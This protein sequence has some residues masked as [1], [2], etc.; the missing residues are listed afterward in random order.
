MRDNRATGFTGYWFANGLEIAAIGGLPTVAPQILDGLRFDENGMDDASQQRMQQVTQV[1]STLTSELVDE[2][3]ALAIANWTSASLTAEQLS[4]L[5]SSTI[6]IGNLDDE[7]ALGLTGSSRIVLDDDALG[8]GW[9]VGS[10]SETVPDG[11]MDLL[12]VL[13]HEM[14]HVLGF[15]DLDGQST[16]D[17]LMAGTLQP[18]QRRSVSSA[19]LLSGGAGVGTGT[20]VAVGNSADRLDLTTWTDDDETTLPGSAVPEVQELH[21]AVSP[22]K[23]VTKQQRPGVLP[24]QGG[25]L[26]VP[27]KKQDELDLLDDLFANAIDALGG[28][29]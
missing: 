19:D 28:L 24:G 11:T 14:G 6:E 9:Y 7:G 27:A 12:T 18:G 13:T 17:S 8:Y 16:P 2:F 10:M 29:D 21:A 20:G 1:G 25:V 3:K 15:S 23:L 22:V 5:T 4:R 26:S